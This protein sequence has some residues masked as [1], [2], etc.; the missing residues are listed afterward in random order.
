MKITFMG[1]AACEGFPA[2][3]CHCEYCCEARKQQGKNIRTR[4]QALIDDELLIDLPADT[5]HH[6]LQ[7]GVEGD[8]IRYLL[9][10]HSHSDHFYPN[11]LYIREDVYAHN[12]RS[13]SLHV[14]CGEGVAKLFAEKRESISPSV[15]CQLLQPFETVVLGSYTITALPARHMAGDGALFYLIKSD[16]TFL[17]AHDTGYFYDEVFEFLAKQ[18]VKLDAI[19]LDCTNVDIPITDEGSHMGLN[20]IERLL[21]RLTECGIVDGKTVK[22]INHFSHNANPLQDVLE[23]R[24]KDYGYE[25]AFDGKCLEL[26]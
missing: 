5:Y 21:K 2:V 12:M 17:Y 10:T 11:E 23:A 7:N 24:V 15:H 9:V 1:T 25:V 19:S 13:P 14:C 16:K 6:F 4:S 8:K 20:N 3:F 26:V 18:N 22:I